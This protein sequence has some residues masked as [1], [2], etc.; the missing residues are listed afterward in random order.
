M[1]SAALGGQHKAQPPS[2]SVLFVV[3]EA[4]LTRL[5]KEAASTATTAVD[6]R[7]LQ[8][9]RARHDRRLQLK[10]KSD[11]RMSRWRDTIE[12][13]GFVPES[14]TGPPLDGLPPTD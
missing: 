7:L 2:S 4:E 11:E 6:A 1:A 3:D 14:N 8:D 10:Q 5:R 12:V 13:C 9:A